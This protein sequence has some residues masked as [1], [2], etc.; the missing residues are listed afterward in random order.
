MANVV[1]DLPSLPV[2]DEPSSSTEQQPPKPTGLFKRLTTKLRKPSESWGG[3]QPQT[4]DGVPRH[5]RRR[6]SPS[7]GKTHTVPILE[8]AWTSP[9]LR[10]AALRERGLLPAQ[11]QPLRDAHGYHLPLSEQEAQLDTRIAVTAGAAGP[12]NAECGSEAGKIAEQWMKKNLGEAYHAPSS[13][14]EL[15]SAE[16]LIRGT[17]L[18]CDTPFI[19]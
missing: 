15:D 6:T 18:L 3:E 11:A 7:G 4:G 9:E 16:A 10:T 8:N 19:C 14:Q 5:R 12:G 2:I 17:L 13:S 1:K